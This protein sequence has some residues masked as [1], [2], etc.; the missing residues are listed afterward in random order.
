MNEEGEISGMKTLLHGEV[1]D[2]L[3]EIDEDY[4]RLYMEQLLSMFTLNNELWTIYISKL[5]ALIKEGEG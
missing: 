1:F 5:K 3:I 2:Q 4:L